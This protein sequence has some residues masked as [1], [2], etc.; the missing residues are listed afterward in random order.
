MAQAA[1]KGGEAD[2]REVAEMLG[3]AGPVR[4]SGGPDERK[5]FAT[6][7]SFRVPAATKLKSKN[8]EFAPGRFF[9]PTSKGRQ[10]GRTQK[11]F[12]PHGWRTGAGKATRR[13]CRS[14]V[15]TPGEEWPCR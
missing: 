10:T 12:T 1:A 2:Q 13:P 5:K 7:C 6:S 8:V 15:A 3:H 11:A 9:W 14:E 4:G